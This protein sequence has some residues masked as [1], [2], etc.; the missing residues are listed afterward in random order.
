MIEK[1]HT[2]N[3]KWE[4]GCCYTCS[5]SHKPD[6]T[7]YISLIRGLAAYGMSEEAHALSSKK[8]CPKPPKKHG[9]DNRKWNLKLMKTLTFEIGDFK[10]QNNI[11][12]WI[13]GGL[14]TMPSM[15]FTVAGES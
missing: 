3:Q 2:L 1:L 12:N 15:I 4:I 10:N 6:A 13:E 9:E 7:A 8:N 5:R 14:I 11:W